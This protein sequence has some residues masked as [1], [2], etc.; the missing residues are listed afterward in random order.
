MSFGQKGDKL[1]VDTVNDEFEKDTWYMNNENDVPMVAFTLI[2]GP[3]H[4]LYPEYAN[5]VWD[6]MK[7]YTR[8]VETGEVIYNPYT[9]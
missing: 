6:F 3:V 7:H 4:A 2:Q 1:V 9:K 8:N 5:I